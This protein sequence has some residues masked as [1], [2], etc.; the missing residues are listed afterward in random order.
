[1]SFSLAEQTL[2]FLEAIL[3]GAAGGLMYDL[4]RA[5][6]RAARTGTL[7]TAL[8]DLVF[9]LAALGEHLTPTSHF[10][11]RQK[12]KVLRHSLIFPVKRLKRP[13]VPLKIY[14]NNYLPI[15]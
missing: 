4:C 13:R 15:R 9:W 2:V 3:L 7:G 12:Q 11:P 6:R 10:H 8:A 14:V 5:A 1:M